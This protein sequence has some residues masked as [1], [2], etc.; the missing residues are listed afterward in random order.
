MPGSQ[1]QVSKWERG[2]VMPE[3]DTLAK[4]ARLAGLPVS[5]F[6]APDTQSIGIGAPVREAMLLQVLRILDNESAAALELARAA[7]ERARRIPVL[8]EAQVP[9]APEPDEAAPRPEAPE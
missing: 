6:Q 1:S 9:G 8:S 2:E 4:I 5:V 7:H 3:G